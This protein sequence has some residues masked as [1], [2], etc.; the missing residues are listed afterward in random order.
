[1]AVP[2]FLEGLLICFMKARYFLTFPANVSGPMSRAS[3]FATDSLDDL[4][5]NTTVEMFGNQLDIG[6]NDDHQKS[7]VILRI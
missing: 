4:P 5:V 6:G 2:T 1:M 3:K 7:T